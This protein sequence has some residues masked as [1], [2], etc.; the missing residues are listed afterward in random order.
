MIP[1]TPEKETG[2]GI[3]YLT[4]PICL[5]QIAMIDNTKTVNAMPPTIKLEEEK[6][7]IVLVEVRT[8]IIELSNNVWQLS[9]PLAFL[10]HP[11]T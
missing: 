6:E 3:T 10:N 7:Q 2:A 5:F 9:Q 4:L 1:S 8:L 11:N